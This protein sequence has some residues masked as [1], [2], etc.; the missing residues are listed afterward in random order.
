MESSGIFSQGY[1][2]IGIAD[3][4]SRVEPGYKDNGPPIGQLYPPGYTMFGCNLKLTVESLAA[5]PPNVTITLGL[6][7]LISS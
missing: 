6:T 5:V 1:T 3:G 7:V 4:K 2:S